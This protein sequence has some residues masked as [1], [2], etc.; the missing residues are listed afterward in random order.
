MPAESVKDCTRIDRCATGQH[1]GVHHGCGVLRPSAR[2]RDYFETCM[3]FRARELGTT[4]RIPNPGSES[5]ARRLH[6]V[7]GCAH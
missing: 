2:Q 7:G 6:P 5:R 4:C 3:K 1:S